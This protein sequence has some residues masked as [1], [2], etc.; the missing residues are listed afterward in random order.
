MSLSATHPGADS[1]GAPAP[2]KPA[3]RSL[4]LAALGVVYGDIGTSPLY[5]LQTVFEPS[6]GLPLTP[7]NVI[8]IVSLIFWS[9]TIVVSLKYVA[10]ILRA[11]N[12][13]EGGIMALLALAA[14]SVA[15][16]PRLRHALLIVGVMGASLFYGDSIITP[17]ISVLSAVEGL[18]VAAPFLKTC[19]IPVTLIAL[20]TLFVMQKHGTSGIGAVFGPV[21]VI[22]F[23][24][25]AVVGVANVVAAPAILAALDPLAG[26]AFCLRHEWL[27]FVALGAVV[28]SLTGAE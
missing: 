26:L 11:N 2:H 20:V 1:I 17:A 19:V 13:G 21:M 6:S 3:L 8:G 18:E 10:L 27:A 12:H 7:L 22:W 25:L 5:T 24:V 4:A 28:L 9:L 14:S 23:V 15:S 16:R